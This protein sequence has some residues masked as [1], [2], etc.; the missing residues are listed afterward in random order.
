MVSKR[1]FPALLLAV[2]LLVQAGRVEAC[3]FCSAVSLTFAQE[4]A[5]SQAAVIARLVEGPPAA[6]LSPR[7]EG[8]LP[9]GRFAVVEVLKGAAVVDEAGLLGGDA[10]P[11]ETILLEEKPA[12]TLFLLMGVEPPKLVWSSPIAV[13]DRAVDYLRKLGDLP[14][15]GADRLAFF[16]KYLEDAD[17]TLARDAYD[18]F[19]VAPYADVRGLESRMDPT[20]LL[21]WIENPKVQS[22]RR[23]LYA[24]MLGVCG[25]KADADR[26]A[27]IL[28]GENLPADKAEIRSGL[29]A[30][31]AC[32]VTLKGPEG[33]DLVD[34]L[35][36]DRKGRDVPFTETYAAVMALRFL[37]EESEV[38]P[39]ER[40]LASLRILLDEPKLAD[41]VIADLA[42]WQ[43]WSVVGRLSE[44]FEKA[45]AENIFVREPVVNYLRA[46]P[47]PEA[48]AAIAK[49][50]KIDPEAVR[51]A[52]TL[53][54]FAGAA[55]AKP[56]DDDEAG[57]GR[58]GGAAPAADPDDATLA[59]RIAPVIG[60][61]GA[62][63]DT[64]PAAEP[65]A[66]PA[67]GPRPLTWAVWAAALVLVALA[68]RSVLRPRPG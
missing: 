37:G 17:E 65:S 11:I 46:C 61:D 66:R 14:E 36:L 3:P 68:A 39:R 29:D 31:I 49:L 30:L 60:D 48:A 38:V 59:A 53:A 50:E 33:L 32:Y 44:L 13:S 12:G 27:E 16:Q 25:T 51:R 10:R 58:P 26:I 43:D 67:E 2:A 63:D 23:R 4:I 5:Q 34:R 21:A 54:G 35:F 57:A 7:A 18:E 19:A 8:P 47:L 41:L 15:K 40:V 45:D 1:K 6:A 24:T 20:Q 56:A 28:K 55:S 42:R 22:N 64:A 9:K 62:G 52:A